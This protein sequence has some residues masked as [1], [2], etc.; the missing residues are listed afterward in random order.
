MAELTVVTIAVNVNMQVLVALQRVLQQLDLL[1]TLDALGLGVLLALA[2][3]LHLVQANHLLDAIFVLLFHTELEFELGQ[4]ELDTRAEM[5]SV[6]FDEIC[7][8]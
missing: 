5:R 7:A 3:A 4:H 2:I 1:V 8:C 6:V